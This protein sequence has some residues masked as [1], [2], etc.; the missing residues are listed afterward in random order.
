MD[1][2]RK[3]TILPVEK[4]KDQRYLVHLLMRQ[5]GYENCFFLHTL[6]CLIIPNM[7][8]TSAALSIQFLYFGNT[9]LKNLIEQGTALLTFTENLYLF[10]L[11]SIKKYNKLG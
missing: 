2:R 8:L 6:N 5:S 10:A 3:A 1:F 4:L 9:L 11:I 7:C